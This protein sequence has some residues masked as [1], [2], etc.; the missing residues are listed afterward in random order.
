M[1]KLLSCI[2][3]IFCSLSLWGQA[4]NSDS[5]TFNPVIISKDSVALI[6]KMRKFE[7]MNSIDSLL[8]ESMASKPSL[9]TKQDFSL[10]ERFLNSGFLK[11]ALFLLIGFV[12]AW[13]VMKF[14]GTKGIFKKQIVNKY[15]VNEDEDNELLDF[16]D[17]NEKI[18]MFVADNQFRNAIKYYFLQTLFILSERELINKNLG[19]TN[20]EYLNE[21]PEQLKVNFSVLVKQYNYVWYGN[22][23][24]DE[25]TFSAFVNNFITFQNSL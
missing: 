2:F 15:P 20:N 5:K 11:V 22:K 25:E 12:L 8:R 3:F 7:Y 9:N 16:V 21:L 10:I 6:K 24:I 17:Y 4:L 23:N 19:K 13:L 18:K 1:S 14:Y